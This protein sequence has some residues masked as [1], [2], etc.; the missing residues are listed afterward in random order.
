[1]NN[2]RV[3]LSGLFWV[4][5][6]FLLGC[7]ANIEQTIEVTPSELPVMESTLASTTLPVPTDT[8]FPTSTPAPATAE[9]SATSVVPTETTTPVPTVQIS[10]TNTKEPGMP[11]TGIWISNP[12]NQDSRV[13]IQFEVY[14]VDGQPMVD[15]LNACVDYSCEWLGDEFEVEACS[16]NL[17]PSGIPVKNGRLNID[18][19]GILNE[20]ITNK[21]RLGLINGE[22][23]QPDVITGT[24][25]LPSCDFWIPLDISYNGP[26]STP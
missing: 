5:S 17:S 14:Y 20:R 1:M 23:I 8:S 16:D 18:F 21:S 26:K 19:K 13:W 2:L 10:S 7:S 11:E 9:P 3:L 15:V 4:A 24:W 12:E 25:V 6:F 22:F